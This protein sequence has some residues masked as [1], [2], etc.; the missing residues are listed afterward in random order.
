[1]KAKTFDAVDIRM[2]PQAVARELAHEMLARVYRQVVERGYTLPKQAIEKEL[3][4]IA[5]H[6]RYGGPLTRMVRQESEFK[7]ALFLGQ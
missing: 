7:A 2:T 1:M 4:R 5:L 6:S 3:D